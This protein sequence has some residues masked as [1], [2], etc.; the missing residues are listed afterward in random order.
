MAPLVGIIA[1]RLIEV[2]PE[3]AISLGAIAVLLLLFVPAVLAA[4]RNVEAR[5][6]TVASVRDES[7]Q[8]PAYLLTYVFPFAFA[9]VDKGSAVW[10][11]VVFGGLLLILLLRTDLSAVNPALLA[12]G[13]HSYSVVTKAGQTVTL[14]ARKAPLPGSEILANQVAGGVFSLSTIVEGDANG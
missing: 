5:P 10:A 14:I 9:T 12:A 3:W 11:Y 1:I 2:A 7:A 6:M 8:V 4:R 13:V